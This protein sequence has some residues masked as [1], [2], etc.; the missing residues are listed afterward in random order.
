MHSVE[1]A[2]ETEPE[3]SPSGQARRLDRKWNVVWRW[4]LKYKLRP[5]KFRG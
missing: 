1:T 5:E 3:E 2:N 4:V